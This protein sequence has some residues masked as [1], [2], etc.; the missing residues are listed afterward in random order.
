M[1]PRDMNPPVR[2]MGAAA[3]SKIRD[4]VL[5]LTAGSFLIALMAC[6]VS[7]EEDDTKRIVSVR[8]DLNVGFE[9]GEKGWFF[10]GAMRIINYDVKRLLSARVKYN[11]QLSPAIAGFVEFEGDADDPSIFI[12]DLGLEYEWNKNWTGVAGNVRKFFGLEEMT[13]RSQRLTINRS[14]LYD[15]LASM[16]IVGRDLSIQGVRNPN[17]PLGL[18]FN[19]GG[20][21][22]SRGFFN[23]RASRKIG[24]PSLVGAA[25]NYVYH[26]HRNAAFV[27]EVDLSRKWDRWYG[28]VEVFAGKDPNESNMSD[29]LL[30]SRDVYFFALKSVA[31]RTFTPPWPRISFLEPVFLWDLIFTDTEPETKIRTQWMPGLNLYLDDN[32]RVRWMTFLDLM[33]FNN[34][35]DTGLSM[36][37]Y[38]ISSQFQA[39]W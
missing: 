28:D 9:T 38:G 30:E 5:R 11:M 12:Q 33:F 23:A 31:A 24:K 6:G 14:L 16:G 8:G 32:R 27:G 39:R 37:S 13:S 26:Y 29:R 35:I 34:G 20:D 10:N 17:S 7:A 4:R 18:F 36:S 19:G 15:Y 1:A 22:D 3:M 2:E 25:L 21:G